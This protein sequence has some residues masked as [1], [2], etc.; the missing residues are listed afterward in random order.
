[1]PLTIGPYVAERL[2]GRGAMAAVY[3]CRD[4]HGQAVAVK[5][6][7]GH[8]PEL[9]PAEGCLSPAMAAR[10]ERE[11]EALSRVHHPGVVGHRGHGVHLGRPYLVMDLVEGTD[12]R[13]YAEK[14]AMRPPVERYARART[15]GQALCEAVGAMHAVGLIHRD[16]KPANVLVDPDGRVVLTDLGVVRDLARPSRTQ[17]GQ[18]VGTVAFA[19]PEQLEG[20]LVDE[21]TDLYGVGATIYSLLTRRRPYES[22]ARPGDGL[23][24]PPSRTDP[25][26]PADLE[27]VVLRLMSPRKE[28]R[29]AD[30][31]EAARAFAG[32]GGGPAALPLAGRGNLVAEAI[33]LLDE[34]EARG[35]SVLLELRGSPGVGR[36]WLAEV[37]GAAAARRG[38]TVVEPG[39]APGLRHAMSRARHEPGTVVLCRQVVEPPPGLRLAHIEVLPLGVAE[40]RRTVVAVAPL[41]EHAARVAERLHRFTGGLPA[42]IIPLLEAH[43]VGARL[44]LPDACPRLP[45]AQ[46]FLQGLELDAIEVLGALALLPGPAASRQLSSIAAVPAEEVLPELQ[47]RGLVSDVDG[48]W[49]LRAECFRVVALD[50][51]PDPDGLRARRE[52]GDPGEGEGAVEARDRPSELLLDGALL[53]AVELARSSLAGCQARGDRAAEARALAE[54]GGILLDVGQLEAARRVLA[55]CSAL[56]K[57]GEDASLRVR[58]H[59]LRA[60]V[61]LASAGETSLRRVAAASALDRVVPLAAGAETRS[62]PVDA[63]VFM[64]WASGAAELGDARASLQAH[65]RAVERVGRLEEADRIRT[66]VGLARAGLRRGEGPRALSVLAELGEVERGRPFVRWQIERLRARATGSELPPAGVLAAG[67]KGEDQAALERIR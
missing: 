31:A 15:I 46:R 13:A 19:A 47:A 61:E 65:Q 66:V 45:A 12:L 36:R 9:G 14:L 52:A 28:D 11:V 56:A 39:D 64:A 24:V 59:V 2:I 26:L 63:L 25:E 22:R 23:P 48:R 41:T 3:L 38:L 33:A 62:D 32:A 50:A 49:S 16:V 60:L 37:V 5:W 4:F 44:L 54:L 1:M 29:Y 21:R 6:M 67:L 58:S 53:R 10:F 7:D 40:L 51:L 35:D 27:A 20:V 17:V 34:V 18:L 55:N 57:A 42:L 30:A 8:L 43:T